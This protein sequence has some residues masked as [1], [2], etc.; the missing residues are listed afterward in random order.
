MTRFFEILIYYVRMILMLLW[1]ILSSLLMLPWGVINWKNPNNNKLYARLYAPIARL[2]MGIRVVPDHVEFLTQQQPC[3]YVLNHQSG[4][5]VM[6]Y[7][8]FY[9][10]KTVLIGKK[11]L[12]FVPMWGL[13]YES[14]GNIL[15]DRKNRSQSVGGL[16]QAMQALKTKGLSIFI[17]PE[18]T[19]NRSG[20]GL[21]PFKKGAFHMAISAQVP[22]VPVVCASLHPLVNEQKKYA[23]SGTLRASVLPPISTQ[24]RTLDQMDALMTE[25]R[26]AMLKKLEE[27]NQPR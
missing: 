14:F 5:D 7:A 13:M 11:E 20:V 6:T 4:M 18:G 25:T 8:S 26:N 9:P 21:L 16:N 19:R 22:I 2:I 3:I 1:I 24:G 10:P 12:R 27:L 23:K 17:F 15:I